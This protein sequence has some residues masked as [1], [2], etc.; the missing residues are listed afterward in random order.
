MEKIETLKTIINKCKDTENENDVKMKHLIKENLQLKNKVM[1]LELENS[2]LLETNSNQVECRSLGIIEDQVL[3]SKCKLDIN[4]SACTDNFQ[5]DNTNICSNESTTSNSDVVVDTKEITDNN[6]LSYIQRKEIEEITKTQE[7]KID[8]LIKKVEGLQKKEEELTLLIQSISNNNKK[9]TVSEDNASVCSEFVHEILKS[10]AKVECALKNLTSESESED[11][12]A[13]MRI[14]TEMKSVPE[15]LTPIPNIFKHV[16]K[17]FG[18]RFKQRK[19]HKLKRKRY[20]SRISPSHSECDSNV[21]CTIVKKK[22]TFHVSFSSDYISDSE[23]CLPNSS[24]DSVIDEHEMNIYYK[25]IETQKIYDNVIR[26]EDSGCIISDSSDSIEVKYQ[27]NSVLGIANMHSVYEQQLQSGKLNNVTK[28][29]L[30]YIK[31]NAQLTVIKMDNS[32]KLPV[33]TISNTVSVNKRSNST[34]GPEVKKL[35]VDEDEKQSK[36]NSNHQCTSYVDIITAKDDDNSNDVNKEITLDNRENNYILNNA[37]YSK[38]A[39]FGSDCDIEEELDEV[40]DKVTTKKCRNKTLERIRKALKKSNGSIYSCSTKLHTVQSV[41]RLSKPKHKEDGMKEQITNKIIS[42]S[43]TKTESCKAETST[44]N[45]TIQ[46]TQQQEN[47][48]DN[49]K[50]EVVKVSCNISKDTENKDISVI[51]TVKEANLDRERCSIGHTAIIQTTHQIGTYEDQHLVNIKKLDKETR[52]QEK[53]FKRP[54]CFTRKLKEVLVDD[55]SSNTTQ[56]VCMV[57]VDT[58]TSTQFQK[59]DVNFEKEEPFI[60]VPKSV[61]NGEPI[62]EQHLQE[63]KKKTKRLKFSK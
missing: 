30:E 34:E 21:E 60:G 22:P 47:N 45:E 50:N 61:E 10:N 5:L 51:C 63:S 52:I 57:T 49:T 62:S 13:V 9:R 2:M 23:S 28:N 58:P 32:S 59:N 37:D 1:E 27:R 31:N 53:Q 38:E 15:S 35:K 16:S 12:K 6:R 8:N 25:P 54:V 55:N 43:L 29:I 39:L 41:P 18:Q 44:S 24:A 36:I 56:R 40:V 26:N 46:Q 7:I 33:L 14:L 42:N 11:E 48:I 3:D 20:T 17:A 19:R 4:G